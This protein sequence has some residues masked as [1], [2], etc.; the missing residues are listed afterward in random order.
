[1]KIEISHDALA[2]RLFERASTEDKMR[3]KVKTFIQERY[4]DFTDPSR[5][6][7]LRVA[8]LN[9]I[10]P[11]L[12][13]LTTALS[14]EE[15]LFIRRSQ[16]RKFWIRAMIG[17]AT[18][19]VFAIMF[20]TLIQVNTSK[21]R[22]ASLNATLRTVNEENEGKQKELEKINKEQQ[23]LLAKFG[24]Q[25]GDLK[26]TQD[27]LNKVSRQ[28]EEL[29][30]SLEAKNKELEKAQRELA[31]AN[32]K[33]KAAYEKL[34][35][36]NTRVVAERN[37]L[38]TEKINFQ[39]SQSLSQKAQDAYKKGNT[40]EA[41]KAAAEA[42]QLDNN[43]PTAIEVLRKINT[44]LTGAPNWSMPPKRIIEQHATKFK[45]KLK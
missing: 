1:M 19:L 32:N 44:D 39:T 31:A 10:E 30:E 28:R 7:L 45:F 18:F 24:I 26:K 17:V 13:S 42:W 21:N 40:S 23:E 14:A 22:F 29:I 37:Q 34:N 3:L 43:S 4:K 16:N 8:D 11:Y 20:A 2:K 38:K 9:Y 25:G 36:E 27:S 35:Q 41:F 15:Q 5:R 12:K 6:T 33:L